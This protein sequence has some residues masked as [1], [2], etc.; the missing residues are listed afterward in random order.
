MFNFEGGN[1]IERNSKSSQMR[2]A[3]NTPKSSALPSLQSSS[4]NNSYNLPANILKNNKLIQTIGNIF[5][6]FEIRND[7]NF[8]IEDFKVLSP[9]G[10]GS[11]SKI[12]LARN[13]IT[14]ELNALK[15]INIAN[16]KSE[17]GE[18]LMKQLQAELESYLKPHNV[19][20]GKLKYILRDSA[21][22]VLV[23]NYYSGGDLSRHLKRNKVFPEDWARY[24]IAEMLIAVEHLHG[25]GVLYR[26]FK[27]D[28]FILDDKGHVI[29]TDF[30]MSCPHFTGS[31]NELMGTPEYMVCICI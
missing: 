9:L 6:L 2:I 29:L 22:V 1:P 11:T 24:Y 27:I 5:R 23:L 21:D 14:R 26:D 31:S 7:K 4:K 20:I 8:K 3:Y 10:E 19:F 13:K 12:F 18:L 15:V 30:G 25:N 16:L 17:N 28:N